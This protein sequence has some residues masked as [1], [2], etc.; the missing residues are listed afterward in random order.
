MNFFLFKQK[1][2]YEMRIS[3]WSSDV[4]SSDLARHHPAKEG[5]GSGMSVEQHLLRL[6]WIGPH[7]HRARRAQSNMRHFHAHGL[8]GDLDVLVAPVELVGL[9]RT[10]VV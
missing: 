4:S 1:T 3:D 5:E 9:D 2:A 7:V 10:S 8:A 6:A